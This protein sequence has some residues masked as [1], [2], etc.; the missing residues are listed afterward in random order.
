M[1]RICNT[2]RTMKVQHEY[3]KHLFFLMEQ[4]PYS[5]ISVLDICNHANGSRRSFYRYFKNK[6]GCLWALLDMV[7]T[8]YYSYKMPIELKRKGYPDE[9]L[10]YLSYH[11]ERSAFY[12]ILLRDHLFDIYIDRVVECAKINGVYAL[13]WFGIA[14]GIYSEDALIFHLHGVMA[15][16][17][18]WHLSGYERSIYEMTDIICHLITGEWAVSVDHKN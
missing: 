7:I 1:Y 8:R 14:E 5:E 18:N 16:I 17:K 10:S 2:P 4:K 12:S 9:V 11:R 6:E 3:I 15:L 13:R